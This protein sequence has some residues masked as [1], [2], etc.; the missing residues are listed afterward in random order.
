MKIS[1]ERLKELV[2]EELAVSFGGVAPAPMLAA[3]TPKPNSDGEG[4]MAKQNLW[5]IAEYAQ[6]MH[7][8]IEDDESL[9]PWIQEKIAVASFMMDSVGHFLQYEKMRAGHEEM[10]HEEE[11]EMEPGEEESEEH[12]F[13]P[14]EEMEHEEEEDEEYEDEEHEGE[15]SDEDEEYEDEEDEDQ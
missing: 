8:L 11:M 9:E 2:Q 13:D 6:E 15:E 10:E 4:Y 5:K 14:D 7:D 1:K 12:F 3:A